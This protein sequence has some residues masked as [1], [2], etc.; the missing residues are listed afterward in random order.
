M[1]LHGRFVLVLGRDNLDSEWGID[2]NN[3]IGKTVALSD[4]ASDPERAVKTDSDSISLC[5]VSVLLCQ[6]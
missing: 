3:S 1:G 6:L 2:N 4:L 5:Q